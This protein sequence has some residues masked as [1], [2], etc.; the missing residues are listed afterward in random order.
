MNV[1]DIIA[2]TTLQ[3]VRIPARADGLMG[4]TPMFHF[5]CTLTFQ[6]RVFSFNYSQGLAHHTGKFLKKL[7]PTG[8]WGR[9]FIPEGD[10]RFIKGSGG[11]EVFVDSLIGSALR[12]HD[13]NRFADLMYEPK[14]PELRSVLVNLLSD[15]DAGTMEFTEFCCEMGYDTDSRNAERVWN[16]CRET[17]RNMT[18]VFGRVNLQ[19]L[20]DN[21][22]E[23]ENGDTQEAN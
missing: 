13:P 1:N 2:R 5:H 6:G 17:E 14:L 16:A 15:V 12:S 7:G 22:E 21:R 11:Q 19:T 18:H 20:I 23:I 8:T 9:I 4:H 10:E 3:S